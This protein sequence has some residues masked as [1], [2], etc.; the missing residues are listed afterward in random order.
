MTAKSTS[1]SCVAMLQEMAPDIVRC[2]GA[3]DSQDKMVERA[4]RYGCKK[5]QI[6]KDH[7]FDQA[8]IDK[9]H[10]NG[11]RCNMFW[12]DDPEEAKKFLKMGIDCILSN[13]YNIVAQAVKKTC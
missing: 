13:D 9:A 3:G 8:M 4:I 5:M 10:E 6:V 7:Y 2:C 11:I 12:S 1:I